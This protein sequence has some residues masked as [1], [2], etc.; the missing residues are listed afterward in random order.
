[1]LLRHCGQAPVTP[2]QAGVLGESA[3]FVMGAR[4][5]GVRTQP[6]KSQKSREEGCVTFPA[7]VA[8]RRQSAC[9][10]DFPARQP[11]RGRAATAGTRAEHRAWRR[12]RHKITPTDFYH[13]VCIPDRPCRTAVRDMGC[14]QMK[15]RLS[16]A[17]CRGTVPMAKLAGL[18][19][20]SSN[21][22]LEVLE[23]WTSII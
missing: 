21:R 3:S 10:R 23:G 8:M 19:G 22:L 9:R 12:F 20:A 5:Q 6:A 13:S 18:Q 14:N 2:E 16:T 17:T 4:A 15:H 7:H 11:S 1:M